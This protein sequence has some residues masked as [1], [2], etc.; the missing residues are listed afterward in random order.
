MP[1][2]PS[3]GGLIIT[4]CA[5]WWFVAPENEPVLWLGDLASLFAVLERPEFE[6]PRD[7]VVQL[8]TDCPHCGDFVKFGEICCCGLY[9]VDVVETVVPAG[10]DLLSFDDLD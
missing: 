5:I 4:P 10:Y 1:A 3:Q 6:L 2:A 9:G 8:R 7:F